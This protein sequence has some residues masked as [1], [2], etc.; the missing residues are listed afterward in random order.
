ME[1][2]AA[3]KPVKGSGKTIIA[4]ARKLAKVILYMLKKN[5]P[6]D[7]VRMTDPALKAAAHEMSLAALSVA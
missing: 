7:P 2:Y 3:M 4:T 6:F 1:R 5:E